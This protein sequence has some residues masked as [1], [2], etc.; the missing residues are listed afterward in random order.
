MNEN[1][2]DGDTETL[3]SDFALFEAR[4]QANGWLKRHLNLLDLPNEQH[5]HC[6]QFAK[7]M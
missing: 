5:R 7:R 3:Q 1:G 2:L 4:T 6:N